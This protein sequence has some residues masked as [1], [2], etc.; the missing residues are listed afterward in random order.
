[1][2]E[3]RQGQVPLVREVKGVLI[4]NPLFC[5]R[6]VELDVRG[7]RP[8]RGL[9][10]FL[11]QQSSHGGRWKPSRLRQSPAEQPASHGMNGWLHDEKAA[12][13]AQAV[14]QG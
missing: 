7:S 13:A 12:E 2:A 1:M 9:P 6:T 11:N 4:V 8:G 3:F 14:Q 10:L 5:A